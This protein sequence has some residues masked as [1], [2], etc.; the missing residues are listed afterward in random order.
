MRKIAIK[1]GDKYS[2]LT[3]IKEIAPDGEYRM[4]SLLCVCG[5]IFNAR[6]SN[7]RSGN[8]HSCGCVKRQVLTT[9]GECV[10]RKPTGEYVS[11]IKAKNRCN[12]ANHDK[13]S[14][15]GG[16]GIEFRFNS[17]KEFIKCIGRKP[18]SSHTLERIDTDGH[19][20]Q[21]NVK[22]A[23]RKEQA[24]NFASRNRMIAHKGKTMCLAEWAERL[25]ISYNTLYARINR[26]WSVDK[27]FIN[28][29]REIKIKR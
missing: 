26:G 17:F 25:G 9:H 29:V 28:K 19:Y 18:T 16:R 4:V 27:A 21:G 15:Y 23:T 12:N 3:V 7:V 22:W 11:Y 5:N 13:Y 24:R 6:I 20:E 8:T 14:Y 10:G 1:T 2:D